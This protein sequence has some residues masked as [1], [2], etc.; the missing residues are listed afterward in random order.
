MSLKQAQ[1]DAGY[2][3]SYANTGKITRGKEWQKLLEKE[4]PDSLLLKKHKEGL[5]ATSTIYATDHGSISDTQELPDYTNR[6]RYLDSGYKLKA[7]Y[8]PT[9]LK[10]TERR[11]LDEVEDEIATTL[12]EI[13]EVI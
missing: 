7:K 6:F 12:L 3:E 4:L 1:I 10:V 8:E 11:T 2:S 5:E 9:E 13:G